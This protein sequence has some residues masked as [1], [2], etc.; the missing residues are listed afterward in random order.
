MALS[1]SFSGS[2]FN[3]HHKVRVDWTGT[4]DIANNTTTIT[5]KMYYVHDWSIDIS[6]R[7]NAHSITIDGTTTT[8]SS[9]AIKSN[10]GT[11]L[12]GTATKTIK[13]NSD[14]AKS[15][16]IS[17][18]FA[19]RATL[20]GTYYGN[21]TASATITL[22]NITRGSQP[23]LSASS[24]AL[25]SA[26]TINTNRTSDKFTHTLTYA[27]NGASGTIASGVGDSATWTPALELANEMPN[28][29]SGTATITCKTYNGSTL[30]D[31]KTLDIT[32]TV[33]STNDFKPAIVAISCSDPTGYE[34][35][36]K[37]YVQGKSKITIQVNAIGVYG[38][39]IVGYKI[40][41]NG[42]TY[43]T[44][45]VTTNVLTVVGENIIT[46]EVTDSRGYTRTST[47]TFTVTEYKSPTISVLKGT[48]CLADGTEDESGAYIKVVIN[49]TIHSLNGGNSALL[50]LEYKK[51]TDTTYTTG[52]MWTS[53]YDVEISDTAII[54]ADVDYTYDLK[55]TATD[56]FSVVAA[57]AQVASAFTIIDFNV[58]GKGVAIGKV[59][60]RENGFEVALRSYFKDRLV[61]DN[62]MAV[63]GKDTSDVQKMLLKLSKT[64]NMVI[65]Y[66]LYSSKSGG[67]YLYG[68]DVN[69]L[70]RG[71]INFTGKPI[72][73]N[74]VLWSGAYGMSASQS[75]TLSEAVSKQAN[76]IVLVFSGHENGSAKN[77]S[78][79]TF[80]VSK[81]EV[82]SI[83]GGRTFVMGADAV[84]SKLG[85]KHLYLADTTITGHEDNNK[86]G[87]GGSGI[88]YTNIYF[89]LR[90]VIGV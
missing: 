25:G 26:V 74:R 41:L 86:T 45:G 69:I 72:M 58:S 1:G 66:D 35:S 56:E 80:Y 38:S 6:A 23:T 44:N 22:D 18:S 17:A 71:Y 32:L 43:T 11:H 16:S 42:N 84:F 60:E 8:F 62:D 20:S 50:L 65:G 89:V 24:V 68:N 29:I 53:A 51:I 48:R 14:G 81:E 49:A 19:L 13:H 27:F 34:G 33:P 21:I 15:I 30:I 9:S 52:K 78:W 88:V 5:A 46:I 73:A 37:T 40:K 61:F 83:T 10:S 87:T 39:T 77:D 2:V 79:N 12:I 4:Q 76:G 67:A 47:A 54:P 28:A 82:S 55:L 85:A 63:Y 3:A 36:Y 7:S 31:T 59:S 75:I 70:S 90:Y 57:T 64:N